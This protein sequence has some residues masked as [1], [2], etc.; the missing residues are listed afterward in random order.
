MCCHQVPRRRFR[1]SSADGSTGGLLGGMGSSWT[2][3]SGRTDML[4][5]YPINP[6]CGTRCNLLSV[7]RGGTTQLMRDRF[8]ELARLDEV[9]SGSKP[10]QPASHLRQQL[11]GI[12]DTHRHPDAPVGRHGEL[13]RRMDAARANGIGRARVELREQLY[14]ALRAGNAEVAVQPLRDL[15]VRG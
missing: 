1:C 9:S 13:L 8:G 7:T 6:R 2:M 10:E 12:G 4:G 5:I 14:R 15:E 11:R 3:A